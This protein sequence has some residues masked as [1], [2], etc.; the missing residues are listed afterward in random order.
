MEITPD[1]TLGELVAHD[2]GYAD[3]LS[4][5]H[6]DY[7]FRGNVSIK[8]ACDKLG[9]NT[10]QIDV[11]INELSTVVC[12]FHDT[13]LD[14]SQWSDE[15]LVEYI[16]NRH[17]DILESDIHVIT[18]CLD[19]LS[20]EYKKESLELEWIDRQYRSIL[21]LMRVHLTKE[22]V[23]FQRIE[24]AQKRN[25]SFDQK[26]LFLELLGNDHAKIGDILNQIRRKTKNYSVPEQACFRLEDTY[27]RM[28]ELDD[29]IRFTVH[30]ENNIL[31]QRKFK[32]KRG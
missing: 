24:E 25:E 8:T 15:F 10:M 11:L 13:S 19:A 3:V 32:E 12:L 9:L 27:Q 6:L 22:K 29:E 4:N 31:Y 14:S 30:L 26:E 18:A 5:Y 20:E 23:V 28:K 1:I 16:G 21:A 17:H 7:A 2:Y